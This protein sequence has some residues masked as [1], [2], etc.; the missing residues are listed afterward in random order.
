[1][2]LRPAFVLQ[3]LAVDPRLSAE[4]KESLE[5]FDRDLREIFNEVASGGL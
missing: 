4:G 2:V 1:M 3:V 5:I